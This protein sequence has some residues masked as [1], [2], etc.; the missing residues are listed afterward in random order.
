MTL[1]LARRRYVEFDFHNECRGMSYS[2]ISKLVSSLE[3]D[4]ECMRCAAAAFS[5]TA[6][7]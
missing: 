6:P 2:N 7:R 5:L 3:R 1:T 4:F